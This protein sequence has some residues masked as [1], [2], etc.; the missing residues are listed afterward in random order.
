MWTDYD[1]SLLVRCTEKESGGWQC[2]A[3]LT[4]PGEEHDHFIMPTKFEEA[5]GGPR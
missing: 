3:W 4:E 1:E 5:W 2:D